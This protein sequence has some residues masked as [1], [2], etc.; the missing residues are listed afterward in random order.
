[1]GLLIFLD[2]KSISHINITKVP[3]P[4]DDPNPNKMI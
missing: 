1:M 2:E 4:K 3:D